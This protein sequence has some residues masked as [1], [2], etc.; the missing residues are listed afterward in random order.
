MRFG[1]RVHCTVQWG[2]G[3]PNNPLLMINTI[4]SRNSEAYFP[5]HAA[6]NAAN[7]RHLSVAHM[8]ELMQAFNDPPGY[9]K[10]LA[11]ELFERFNNREVILYPTPFHSPNDSGM[12]LDTTRRARVGPASANA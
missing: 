12:G 10:V 8:N 2:T 4:L 9:W 5:T 7:E 6:K 3:T 1:I 11:K